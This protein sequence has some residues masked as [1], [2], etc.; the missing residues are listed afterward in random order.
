MLI[1]EIGCGKVSEPGDYKA[2]ENNIFW[3]LSHADNNELTEMGKLGYKYL[4]RNL[5]KDVSVGKYI[6]EIKCL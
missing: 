5:T 6:T 3:F 2:I 1:N 4:I